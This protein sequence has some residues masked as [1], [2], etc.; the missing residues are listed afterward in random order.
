MARFFGSFP[1]IAY[2]LTGKQLKTFNKVTDIFFRLRIIREILANISAYYEY[3]IREGDTPEIL[4]EKIYGEAEAHWVILMANDIIDAQYDWPLNNRD[5]KKFLLAKY[6]SIEKAKTTIHHYEKVVTRTEE[7]SGIQTELRY[8]I[9]YEPKTNYELRTTLLMDGENTFAANDSIVGNGFTATVYDASPPYYTFK[10]IS[11]ENTKKIILG[12]ILTS[13]NS[14][15]TLTIAGSVS[16]DGTLYVNGSI[17]FD[18]GEAFDT[19]ISLPDV[20]YVQTF[21][22]GTS[23]NTTTTTTLEGRTITQIT[24]RNAISNYDYEVE[25]NES[26]RPIKIIKPEYYPKII[27]DFD[28]LTGNVKTPYIRRLI[29]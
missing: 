17:F 25:H 8:Q 2:D 18:T 23:N 11:K 5:F 15:N 9:D 4:A 28:T 26:K 27:K 24:N 7:F 12:G 10:D 21:N 29:V 13:T 3:I 20:Q 16:T 14:S 6:G 22:W 19:Y 1:K